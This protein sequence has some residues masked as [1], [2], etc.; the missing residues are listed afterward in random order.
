MLWSLCQLSGCSDIAHV[1]GPACVCRDFENE[2]LSKTPCHVS[3]F[4]CSSK[5]HPKSPDRLTFYKECVGAVQQLFGDKAKNA[6]S[7][8]PMAWSAL[9]QLTGVAQVDLLKMD[10]EGGE[11]SVF[12]ELLRPTRGPH[13]LP[14]QMSFEVHAGPSDTLQVALYQQLWRTGYRRVYREN[15]PH[16]M[17]CAEFTMLRV[18]C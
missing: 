3:T 1:V 15:N 5:P 6:S 12:E 10:I 13:E 14:F 16:C 9:L 7:I 11:Y 4:D 2:M 18:F 17:K 8:T